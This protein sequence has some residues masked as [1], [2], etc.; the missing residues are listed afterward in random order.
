MR[1]YKWKNIQDRE[2]SDDKC[3]SSN[4]LCVATLAIFAILAKENIKSI[5]MISFAIKQ[6]VS[7]CTIKTHKYFL[8]QWER[9]YATFVDLHYIVH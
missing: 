2:I 1:Y 9:I 6:I 4:Q 3:S 8:Q 7:Q 5:E